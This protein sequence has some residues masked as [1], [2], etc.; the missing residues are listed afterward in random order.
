V[1][2]TFGPYFWG[3]IASSMG[4]WA[5]SIAAVVLIFE[6]TG[7][8]L[9]VGLVTIVQFSMPLVV[10]PVGGALADR[11]DRRRLLIAAQ[12]A[13]AAAAGAL[14]WALTWPGTDRAAAVWWLLIVSFALGVGIAITD[15]ARHALVPALVAPA[16]LGQAVAL[17]TVTFN[18]GRAAGPAVAGLLLVSAGAEVVMLLTALCYAVFVVTLLVIRPRPTERHG[19]AER[20]MAAG[21]RHVL[22]DRR[23]LALLL[24][25]G[26]AGI[27]SD[28]VI[29]LTP[30]LAGELVGP[31]GGSFGID[32]EEL[33]VG[34]LAAAFGVG[35]VMTMFGL[36]F[37]HRRFGR[38]RVGIA[39][40]ALLGLTM[41]GL[42][43]APNLAVAG[44]V[45]ITAGVGYFLAITSL[46]TLLQLTIPEFLRG[47]VMALW[48]VC[49]LGSRPVAAFVDSHLAHLFS[50]QTALLALA[51]A[52]GVA[53][54]LVARATHSLH[55]TSSSGAA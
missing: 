44:A 15:P 39:G 12:G 10:A 13:S 20:G 24:G 32:S 40:L 9:Y 31:S 42:A 4:M 22:D 52:V 26:V 46:T 37:L 14:A 6:L 51:A 35:A 23:K 19:G 2:R 38:Q 18:V 7:S 27:A 34:L 41:A 30:L 5:Y 47:R 33:A 50:P 55:E 1:D 36:H 49:F 43:V 45:L 28:P 16:D 48:G 8:P 21:L 53:A 54:V 11:F 3:N 25:V 29:T 17:N